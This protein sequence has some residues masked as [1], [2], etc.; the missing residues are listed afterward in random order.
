MKACLET[1][2]AVPLFDGEKPDG[3]IVIQHTLLFLFVHEESEWTK[4]RWWDC[5]DTLLHDCL[6]HFSVRMDRSPIA[7]L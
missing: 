1:P 5:N 6:F 4:A 7:G 3:G 2:D